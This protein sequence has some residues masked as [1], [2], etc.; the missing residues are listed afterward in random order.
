MNP[1]SLSPW[2]SLRRSRLASLVTLALLGATLSGCAIIHSNGTD[3]VTGKQVSA[4]QLAQVKPGATKEDVVDLLGLP[5]NTISLGNGLDVWEWKYTQNLND[6]SG[7]IFL[8]ES[9]KTTLVE[10]TTS[11][12]FKDGVV[13]KTWIK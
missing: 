13:V 11:V 1:I 6:S 9:D 5:T 12:E 2:E 4:A 10:Q 8:F 3:R 7:F